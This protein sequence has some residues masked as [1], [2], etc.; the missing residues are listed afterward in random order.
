MLDSVTRMYK[1]ISTPEAFA[2]IFYCDRCGRGWSSDIYTFNIRGFEPPV[3]ETIKLM[4][5][6][7]QHEKAYERAN[8][9]A[10]ARFNRCP[11]CGCRICDDCLYNFGNA[12]H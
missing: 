10:G 12:R 8:C 11:H 3:D 9:E 2:F 7:E 4:L 1:D 5:W 6:N